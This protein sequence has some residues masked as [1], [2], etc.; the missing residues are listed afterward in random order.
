MPVHT[1]TQS[2][3]I[4]V[5]S[6]TKSKHGYLTLTVIQAGRSITPGQREERNGT[7]RSQSREGGGG[8]AGGICGRTRHK[9]PSPRQRPRPSDR[10]ATRLWL[11]MSPFP[12]L[13]PLH[14]HFSPIEL[15]GFPPRFV[16]LTLKRGE[17]LSSF[18]SPFCLSDD[19][20]HRRRLRGVD[21][22]F[23]WSVAHG[24][25]PSWTTY[26]SRAWDNCLYGSWRLYYCICTYL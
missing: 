18:P 9:D 23:C 3:K 6:S 10:R 14:N 13:R 4:T 8:G 21:T 17:L 20:F 11:T 2:F 15:W 5:F 22:W 25:H 1:S 24:T 16:P 19:P 26:H 12:S 7:E